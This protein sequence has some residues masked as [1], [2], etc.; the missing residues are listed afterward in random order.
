MTTTTTPPPGVHSVVETDERPFV[1]IT[2]TLTMSR[3]KEAADEMPRLIGWLG[4]HGIEPDG[5]P[6]LRFLVIDMAA[7]MV[8]QAG[9]PVAAPVEGD[10]EVGAGV[11]PAGR[12]VSVVHVGHYDGLYG[13]TANLLRWAGE[14]DLHFD[15]H[16]SDSGEVWASRL[17][18]YETEPSEEPDPSTWVTR[19]AFKLAD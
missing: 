6:F 8:V 18:W 17:E 4:E 13:A 12:Y 1:G 11:L 14:R 19:L 16:P 3:L 9:V 10:A 5:P 2:R 7:D 15:K